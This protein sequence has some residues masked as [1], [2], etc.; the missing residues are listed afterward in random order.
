MAQV[1]TAQKSVLLGHH[2]AL[3]REALSSLLEIERFRVLGH[4][5]S[6][7][8]VIAM[9]AKHQPDVIVVEAKMN[10]C[11]AEAFKRIVAAAPNSAVAMI[12]L[13]EAPEAFPLAI[14]AGVR[15]YLSRDLPR[16]QFVESLRLL[17]QGEIVISRDMGMRLVQDMK[18]REQEK[19]LDHLSER[20]VEVLGLV[21]LGKT[22]REIAEALI[23]AENTVKVHLR[24]ILAKLNLRNRQQAAAYAAQEGLTKG[25]KL[26]EEQADTP[27]PPPQPIRIT[28]HLSA[29]QRPLVPPPPP[30]TRIAS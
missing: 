22:N 7:D 1:D 19:P 15:G 13:P 2:H 21:G 6:L 24:N 4:S 29:Y 18:K 17:A 16:K 14:K 26:E 8:Q 23:V 25:L 10:G 20:E 5:G 27:P 12:G 9:A 3:I 28:R 30:P 11:D